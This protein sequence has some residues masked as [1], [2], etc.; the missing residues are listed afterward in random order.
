MYIIPFRLIDDSQ[1]P[2]VVPWHGE[3]ETDQTST[4]LLAELAHVPSPGKIAPL[5]QPYL[6]QTPP[7]KREDLLAAGSVS[8]IR[9]REFGRQFV[10]LS[11]LDLYSADTGLV[12][13]DPTHG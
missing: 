11:N 5:L 2:V 12:L 7:S 4:R 8:V 1:V 10:V 6:V 13:S 3:H 9:E